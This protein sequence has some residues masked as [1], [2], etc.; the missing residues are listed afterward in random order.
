MYS[1]QHPRV[2]KRR[3]ILND[4][5]MQQKMVDWV[6]CK[7]KER[8]KTATSERIGACCSLNCNAEC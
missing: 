4:E 3:V 6:E 7:K 1:Y 5:K 8:E 2:K